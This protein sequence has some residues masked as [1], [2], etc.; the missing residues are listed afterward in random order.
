MMSKYL[1]VDGALCDSSSLQIIHARSLWSFLSQRL[2]SYA[3]LIECQRGTNGKEIVVFDVDIEVSQVRV[4]DIRPTERVAVVFS[5]GMVP[6]VLALRVDFP[7]VPHINPTDQEF[8]RSLCLYDESPD[9]LS[10]RWTPANFVERLRWWL[11]E[12]AKGTLHGADQPLEP[13]LLGGYPLLVLPAD[14]LSDLGKGDPIRLYVV[15]RQD[16][17][18]F[19]A[20]RQQPQAGYGLSFAACAFLCPPHVHGVIRRRPHS[21]AMVDDLLQETGF[22]LTSTLG[23]YI[24]AHRDQLPLVSH[25]ILIVILPKKRKEDLE[26]EILESWAFLLGK[27]VSD[28]GEALG[29]WQMQNGIPGHLLGGKADR[30]ALEA[31]P[32]DVLNPTFELSRSAAASMNGTV[33]TEM[34]ITAIG[35]GALGSQVADNLM[36]S[37]FGLWTPVDPDFLL[38]HNV[39]RHELTGDEVGIA[40]AEAMRFRL[41]SILPESAPISIEADVLRPGEHET[42]VRS[43]LE[44]CEAI[45]DFSAS[46]SVARHLATQASIARTCSV[47]LNSRGSDLII[48]CE[49]S[50]RSI[51][52]DALEFQYYRAV[53]SEPALGHHFHIPGEKLRYARS[54]RDLTSRVSQH[55]VCLHSGIAAGVLPRLL[56]SNEASAGIWS[57][58]ASL[59]VRHFTVEVSPV[60][61]FTANGW[62]IV[63]DDAFLLTVA[64]LRKKK[65]RKETGGVLLG[66]FD[67]RHK[68]A[69]IVAT[70]P[71]PPDSEEW[72]TLYIRGC[73]GLKSATNE[74]MRTSDGQIQYVGEWHSHPDRYSTQPSNDDRKVFAWLT[75]HMAKDGLSPLMLIA[76][77]ED[78]RVFVSNME[79]PIQVENP[80]QRESRKAVL[81]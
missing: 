1:E 16:Q 13:I 15:G 17:K 38:P 71:S 2:N 40:K 61:E 69:Y 49:N 58:D 21:L 10:L 3:K 81:Q 26:P 43:A 70:I 51:R 9:E 62:T 57:A 29:V 8:P 7:W 65:S 72:P 25:M 18:V 68:K 78:F 4:H 20:F 76:G 45:I 14:L 75:E 80:L 64:G 44:Q 63:V 39:A 30:T 32:V 79:N 74:I 27:P 28:I 60:H 56:A 33:A 31:I 52:S 59:A 46:Q 37:G 66:S 23:E 54:C 22:Q 35:M 19:R 36:R 73:E 12:T 77:R 67:Q 34:K 24:E 47:F 53:I 55:H 11:A 48:L 5:T 50:S 41:N 42:T 6:E